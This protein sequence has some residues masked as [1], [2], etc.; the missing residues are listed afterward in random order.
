MRRAHK[1]RNA[2]LTP[3]AR[4]SALLATQGDESD[5]GAGEVAGGGVS[6]FLRLIWAKAG[7]S[8][9]QSDG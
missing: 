3:R 2:L 1:E 7:Y 8:S 5:V 6:S 9:S 4:S